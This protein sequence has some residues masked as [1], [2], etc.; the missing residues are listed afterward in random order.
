LIKN[1]FFGDKKEFNK[2]T[3]VAQEIIE[4]FLFDKNSS[5]LREELTLSVAGCKK[6]DKKQGADGYDSTRK[7]YVE[8]K[9]EYAHKNEKGKQKKLTGGGSFNDITLK[10]INDIKDWD[11]LCSGFADDKCLF[12]VRFPANHITSDLE[13]KL[14]KKINNSTTRK[15]VRFGYKQYIDCPNLEILYFDENNSKKC[16]SKV[17]LQK[18]INLTK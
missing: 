12:V 18:F 16:M 17:M 15:S 5:T 8:V 10:K 3:K 14:L 2:L 4:T 9:P 13:A 6:I 11:I 1:Y 7:K